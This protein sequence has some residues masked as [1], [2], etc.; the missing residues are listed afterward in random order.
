VARRLPQLDQPPPLEVTGSHQDLLLSILHSN[1]HGTAPGL[2][3]QQQGAPAAAA[4]AA[5]PPA[6]VMLVPSHGTANNT[7]CCESKAVPH[8][9]HTFHTA[10]HTACPGLHQGWRHPKAG[11]WSVHPSLLPPHPHPHPHPPWPGLASHLVA[12]HKHRCLGGAVKPQEL[13]VAAQGQA[14]DAVPAGGGGRVEQQ[15]QGAR[16]HPRHK[17]LNEEHDMT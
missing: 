14:G 7:Q 5:A 4:A 11:G 1:G 17:H 13:A 15:A 6:A 9:H 16:P 8:L 2:L 10:L 12:H 3:Q